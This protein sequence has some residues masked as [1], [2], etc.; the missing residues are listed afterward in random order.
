MDFKIEVNEVEEVTVTNVS[1]VET[2]SINDTRE[3]IAGSVGMET[4]TNYEVAVNKPQIN[5]SELVGDKTTEELGIIDDVNAYIE[6][7]KEELRGQ[8]GKDGYTPVKGVDYFDGKNGASG[9][10]G[11][12]CSHSWSGTT[13][14][15][16]SA[17]GT[18]SANLKGATGSA[19]VNGKDG[20]TPI[21]GKDYFDGV[22]GKDGKTPVKGTDYYTEA[23]KQEMVNLVMAAL[24]SSEGVSY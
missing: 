22:N 8:D 16:T 5:G 14:T 24:P 23:D 13:L 2:M 10:D 19:G 20:Y 15:I 18:T 3:V 17:S 1:E 7:H 21:K 12:S 11:I 6:E 9:K 4:V